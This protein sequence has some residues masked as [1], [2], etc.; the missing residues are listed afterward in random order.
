LA[1][2]SKRSAER[3]NA[4]VGDVQKATN[5]TVMA[6]EEGGKTLAVTTDLA[7]KTVSAFNSVNESVQG[8]SESA[9]QIA[10]NIKQQSEA[11]RQV[12]EAMSNLKTGAREAAAGISQTKDGI[13]TLNT[14]AQQLKAMT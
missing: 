10:L 13:Q 3:I 7:H 14:A 6:T 8:A 9:Q 11:I 12:L 2:E 5:S 1:E 4:L